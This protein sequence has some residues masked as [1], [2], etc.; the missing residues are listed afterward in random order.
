MSTQGTSLSE[1]D[2]IDIFDFFNYPKLVE[3]AARSSEQ[4]GSWSS[5]G[6]NALTGESMRMP[7]PESD[8]LAYG[9]PFN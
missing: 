3:P 1:L 8:W 7:D 2:N 5:H 6:V 4:A 9:T